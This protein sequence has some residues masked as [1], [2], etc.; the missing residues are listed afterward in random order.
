MVYPIIWRKVNFSKAL[1]LT[2]R[3]GDLSSVLHSAMA[4]EM[5]RVVSRLWERMPVTRSLSVFSN[6]ILSCLLDL[7]SSAEGVNGVGAAQP[8]HTTNL[9]AIAEAEANRKD[10]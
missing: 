4:L 7:Q 3:S 2:N 9:K 10:E 6:M 5:K 1:D 8:S